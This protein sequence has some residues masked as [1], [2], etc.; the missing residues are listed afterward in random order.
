MTKKYIKNGCNLPILQNEKKKKI[1]LVVTLFN[2]LLGSQDNVITSGP[3]LKNINSTIHE[4]KV[5][6][7]VFCF[8]S[9]HVPII[10]AIS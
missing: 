10:K 5:Q 1:W 4:F 8:I 3:Q 9:E 6:F 2:I 7:N